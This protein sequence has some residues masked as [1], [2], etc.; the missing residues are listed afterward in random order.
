MSETAL[1]RPVMLGKHFK[2]TPEGLSVEGEPDVELCRSL[3][4]ALRTLETSLQFAIGDAI[5]YFEGRF[6]EM[7]ADII[8]ATGLSLSSVK[9][10][11]WTSSQVPPKNRMMNRGLSYSHH[12]AVAR[13]KPD[14]QRQWLEKA[15]N[16]GEIWPVLRLKAEMKANGNLVEIGWYLRVTC[17]S[18]AHQKELQKQLELDGFECVPEVR[19]G[20]L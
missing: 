20:V 15:V 11:S 17:R 5:L 9:V 7:A 8:D 3:W 14:D 2:I 10:Y 12:Q 13:L 6:G 16:G 19:R 4:D 18:A 1:A